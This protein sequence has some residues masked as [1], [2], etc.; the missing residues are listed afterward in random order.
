[1]ALWWGFVPRIG[2]DQTG[3]GPSTNIE[4]SHYIQLPNEEELE[5]K[6][7]Q[8]GSS[9]DLQ[10]IKLH[11]SFGWLSARGGST[12]VFGKAKLEAIEA[13]PVLKLYYHTIFKGVLLHGDCHLL[14]IGYS[15]GDKH[16]NDVLVEAAKD[17]GLKLFIL[18]SSG[19]KALKERLESANPILWK[20]LGGY[21][22][23]TIKSLYPFGIDHRNTTN[24]I[25]RTMGVL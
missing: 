13:E 4:T 24:H 10:Y 19:P 18:T 6:K 8:F 25:F 7:Q 14:V 21:F 12:M 17:H 16:I 5:K 22:S 9:G 3:L 11:G 23:G 15:F 20:S 2:G 1:M